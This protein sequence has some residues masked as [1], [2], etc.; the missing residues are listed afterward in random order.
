MRGAERLVRSLV[1]TYDRRQRL[2]VRGHDRA[3]L[4]GDMSPRR[5]AETCLRTPN[6]AAPSARIVRSLLDRLRRIGDRG[7]AFFDRLR[8]RADEPQ[9]PAALTAALPAAALLAAALPAFQV[10]S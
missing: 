9:A 2:G 1:S 6:D 10:S 8:G 3:F 4:R 7:A 5:K